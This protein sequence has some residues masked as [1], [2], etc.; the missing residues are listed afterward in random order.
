MGGRE[1]AGLLAN[2]EML[3][4]R[5]VRVVQ[6]LNTSYATDQESFQAL[7]KARLLLEMFPDRHMIDQIYDVADRV[8]PD[9]GHLVLQRARFE[10]LRESPSFERAEALLARSEDLLPGSPIVQHARAE[11]DYQAA[12]RATEPLSRVAALRRADALLV[13][14]YGKSAGPHVWH[15]KCKIEL[16]RLRS[17]LESDQRSDEDEVRAIQAAETAVSAALQG[18]PDDAHLLDS[19]AK[20]ADLLNQDERALKAL[21]RA[22]RQNLRNASIVSR[23]CRIYRQRGE[24]SKAHDLLQDAS[25]AN[26]GESRYSFERAM[27]MMEEDGDGV[28]IEQL[29]RRSFSAGDRNHFAQFLYARQ[30]YINGDV[31]AGR[32]RFKELSA[33]AGWGPKVMGRTWTWTRV[34]EPVLLHGRVVRVEQWHGFVEREGTGDWVYVP[35][36]ENGHHPL[37]DMEIGTRIHFNVGF[38]FRGPFA[39][40]V[41]K[42]SGSLT[43]SAPSVV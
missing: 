32:A 11:L 36:D 2:P 43:V 30:V 40:G 1:N 22:A 28:T 14:L 15:T 24:R 18:F 8:A 19:E 21:E 9:D 42:D 23:L 34:G 31:P 6:Y 3:F 5:V 33:A 37:I 20:L 27:L 10:M 35:R 25:A 7:T 17:V 39:L 13:G 38:T 41:A 16:L 4:D 26:P 29:L 12:L